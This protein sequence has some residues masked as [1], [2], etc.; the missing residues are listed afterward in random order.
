MSFCELG[1]GGGGGGGGDECVCGVQVCVSV[2]YN[3]KTK[4]KFSSKCIFSVN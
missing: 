2:L 3:L 4:L 1:G